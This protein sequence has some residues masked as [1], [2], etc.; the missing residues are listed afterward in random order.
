[1]SEKLRVR[2]RRGATTPKA[3]PTNPQT[4]VEIVSVDVRG[5]KMTFIDVEGEANTWSV[6]P[7]ALE[8]LADFKSG[9]TALITWR[10]NEKGEPLA[11]I[12]VNPVPAATAPKPPQPPRRSPDQK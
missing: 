3:G 7:K 6:E 2:Q 1:M 10:A 12:D 11:V 5:G 4:K 9:G 8:K